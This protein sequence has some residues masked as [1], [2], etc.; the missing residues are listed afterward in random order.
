[1]ILNF[2]AVLCLLLAS[3]FVAWG[4]SRL[5]SLPPP[6]PASFLDPGAVFRIPFVT[7]I[8]T[9]VILSYGIAPGSGP[10]GHFF[11]TIFGF[12]G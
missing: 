5:P 6:D 4:G 8:K 9:F 7:F 3:A 10:P 2:Q 1:M 11:L 12:V